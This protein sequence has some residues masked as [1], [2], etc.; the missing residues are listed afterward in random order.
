M[1]RP[2]FAIGQARG[3]AIMST[4]VPRFASVIRH[5]RRGKHEHTR[6]VF[7]D[8][9]II[10]SKAGWDMWPGPYGNWGS[11]KY[12]VASL[13]QSLARM[14]LDYVDVFY[15]HRPDPETPLEE[16]MGALDYIVRSGRALYAGISMYPADLTRRATEILSSLGTPCLIH[17]PNYSL[18]DRWIE[19]GLLEVL[20]EE[21]VGCIVFS[22]LAQG[23]LT[24]RYLNGI[25][26]GSRAARD[27]SYLSKGQVTN[28]MQTTVRRLSDIALSRGQ[29][30]AQLAIA[31]VLR[32]TAVTSALVGAS[33][34]AQIEDAVGALDNTD[35]SAEE[36]AA[37][38]EI[39]AV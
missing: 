26:E 37:I 39:L 16:T 10:S 4:D 13:D 2:R 19:D 20:T 32:Q 36:L 6:S 9:L 8:E 12:L 15:H 21:G 24:D 23:L 35:F 38:D 11:R 29:S 30:M 25:P 33:R 22:P 5:R 14:G 27:D 31:W 28:E 1:L 17:Q 3:R 34:T 18:L 7:R